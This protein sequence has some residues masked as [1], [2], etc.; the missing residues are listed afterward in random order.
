MNKKKA[1]ICATLYAVVLVVVLTASFFI[2]NN[3]YGISLY[4]LITGVI[5]NSWLGC[6]VEKFYKWLMSNA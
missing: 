3:E 4:Q 5:A 6:S 1:V 2:K